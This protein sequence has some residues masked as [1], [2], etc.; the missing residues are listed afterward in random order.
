[1]MEYAKGIKL[2]EGYREVNPDEVL[3]AGSDVK[4][5]FASGKSF[6][7][8]VTGVK[9]AVVDEERIKSGKEPIKKQ[10][11]RGNEGMFQAAKAAVDSG[12][13]NPRLLAQEVAKKPRPITTEEEFSLMYDRMRIKNELRDIRYNI[14]RAQENKDTQAES[15][16]IERRTALEADLDINDQATTH[17]GS[18]VGRSLQARTRMVNEDYSLEEILLRARQDNGGT[19]TEE[20]RK[21]YEAMA[22]EIEEANAKIREYEEKIAALE[23]KRAF[24]K[25]K[26][27]DV[28]IRYHGQAKTKR[29]AA[30]TALDREFK[31]LASELNAVLG[32]LHFN[33]DPTAIKI[34]ALMARNRIKAGIMTPD[35]IVNEI[36]NQIKE[37]YPEIEKRDIRD[38]ISGYGKTK[39]LSKD[40]IDVQL[41]EAK[42]LMRLVSSYEDAM[43]GQVPLRSGMQRDKMT[44]AVR[45]LG[46][47]VRQAMREAGIDWESSLSPE[48]QWKT[49]LDAVKTRLRNQIHD[50]TKQIETGERT[51][52]KIGIKYDE[53]AEA[54][55]A[56]RD[57]LKET[58]ISIE[59]KPGMSPEQKIKLAMASVEKSIAEYER[60]ISE[61]DLSPKKQ[62]STTP[63]TPELKVLRERRGELKDIYEDMKREATPKKS[64]EEIALKSYKTRMK[65]RIEELEGKLEA[66]DFA[67]KPK[68]QTELDDEGLTLKHNLDRAIYRYKEARLKDQLARRSWLQKFG[69]GIA[70]ISNFM[71]SI[72]A[73]MDVSAVFRQ[74]LF[75]VVSHPIV[76]AKALPAMFKA[77]KND[78]YRFQV[79]QDI[80]SRKNYKLYQDAGLELTDIGTDLTVME[81]TFMS[82]LAEKIPGVAGSQRA[83][84]TFLNKIRVDTFDLLIKNLVKSEGKHTAEEAKAIAT[85]INE[86]T[87]RGK[88]GLKPNTLA[89]L[90]TIFF[91]PRLVASRF[92]MLAGHSMWHGTKASR[93][94]IAKEYGRF[95]SGMALVYLLAQLADVD[96]EWD[97]RSSDFGKIKIGDTRLDPLG[98]FS[99]VIVFLS[100]VSSGKT[101]TLSGNVK[102]IRGDNV[103]YGSG[104]TADI[105]GRFIRT[106]LAPAIGVSIDV[107]SGKDVVG[108][109]VIVFD[110]DQIKMPQSIADVPK[111]AGKVSSIPEKI[112]A[113]MALV[114]TYEAMKAN[115]IPEGLALGTLGML[116]IGVQT[117]D[118]R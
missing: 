7:K 98:G 99:Q 59:G 48:D 25:M 58:L 50:I 117:Y 63:E 13:I 113:P 80:L 77:F 37:A 23:A 26:N 103:P 69:G 104:N 15:D 56:Q 93:K 31:D 89:G 101:K 95:L 57:K 118:K 55:R 76:G 67:Q 97:P 114:D 6:V 73:S 94:L 66:G 53:E 74:G 96:I 36:Y 41:R 35:G 43:S 79:E 22:K 17:G 109:K 105:I 81:E 12:E 45:E 64:P 24:Q 60:R 33:F 4:M 71:R 9:H 47:Q 34:M 62:G 90:N 30:K 8:D 11:P 83:Y 40:E 110:K 65:N 100:R 16:L 112:V 5:D 27:E 1:L 29:A 102:P 42:R 115:G 68:K 85:L 106:K 3:P 51:P 78:K 14:S 19:L 91:A 39:Q 72:K 2:P 111:Q 18:E 108:N 84:T 32:G 92:Q 87:G 86:S 61:K 38:A 49:A 82:R 28:I 107:L 88:V 54:L 10:E 46:R 52:K 70:E 116:G 20:M 75:T 44:D 21:K